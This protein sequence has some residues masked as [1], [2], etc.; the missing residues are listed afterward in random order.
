MHL[1]KIN[2]KKGDTVAAGDKIGEVGNTGIST[3]PHL[4]FRIC[5]NGVYVNPMDYMK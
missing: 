1:S 4:D 3:G 5:V 2:V